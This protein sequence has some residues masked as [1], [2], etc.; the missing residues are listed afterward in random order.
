M[1]SKASKVSESV[2]A[3]LQS[4]E[5]DEVNEARA[6]I[7]RALATKLDKCLESEAAS[8]AMATPGI[9]KELRST[10]DDI[11]ESTASSDEFVSDLFAPVQHA[12]NA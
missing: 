3:L 1:S 10:L 4:L 9:S 12:Q 7:A 6:S 11:I 5:L 2:D 8:V